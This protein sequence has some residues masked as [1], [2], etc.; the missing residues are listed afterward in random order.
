MMATKRVRSEVK[1]ANVPRS[2]RLFEAGFKTRA[3][4]TRCVNAIIADLAADRIAASEAN[5]L[6]GATLAHM[7]SLDRKA[8][9]ER[10][11]RARKA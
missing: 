3:E 9:R 6:T 7:R 11:G 2:R 10:Q 4:A 8:K 5:Q 1:D